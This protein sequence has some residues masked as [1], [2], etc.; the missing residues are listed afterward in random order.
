[1]KLPRASSF[2]QNMPAGL[3]NLKTAFQQKAQQALIRG[4]GGA[5]G[6]AIMVGLADLAALPLAAVP[7]ATSIVLVMA[8]CES[9]P[10]QPRAIAGGHIL[11]TLSGLDAMVCRNRGWDG[12]VF[13]ASHRHHAPA[14]RNRR[15]CRCHR[16]PFMDIFLRTGACWRDCSNYFCLLLSPRHPAAN[17]AHFQTLSGQARGATR[18]FAPLSTMSV[19]TPCARTR[20]SLSVMRASAVMIW[21]PCE[22]TR[23]SARTRPVRGNIGREKLP[24][25][26][27]VV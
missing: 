13:D 16:P 24:F 15:A 25:V 8:A 23:P 4:V 10:A 26:S 18:Y 1:M 3:P 22:I 9:A 17:L 12:R 7:F 5:A 21:R 27:I 19:E 14:S 2:Q 11:S 6:V 20:P